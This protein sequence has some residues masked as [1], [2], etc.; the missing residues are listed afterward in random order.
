MARESGGHQY[1]NGRPIT[2]SSGA[3]GLMQLMPATYDRLR[4]RY[5]L[6]GDVY[7]PHDNIFAGA[8]LI[9]ELYDRYGSPN[10]LAAYTL[11]SR[12]MDAYL[13]GKSDLPD[14]T[15]SYMATAAPGLRGDQPGSSAPTPR[16]P[17]AF[18]A[19]SGGLIASAEAA[20]VRANSWSVQVGAYRDPDQARQA[21][22]Q[23]R[24]AGGD[25]LTQGSVLIA[26][27]QHDGARYYRARITGLDRNGA[28]TACTDLKNAGIGCW[29]V[30]PGG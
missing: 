17:V 4:V 20:P 10:F 12:R 25:T 3:A 15:R 2:S 22:A 27:T 19:A 18:A 11:G 13:A 24:Q 14:S 7:D 8:G 28:E 5:G 9:R 23:A 1:L 26:I 6:G 16:P 30:A 21:A 29:A